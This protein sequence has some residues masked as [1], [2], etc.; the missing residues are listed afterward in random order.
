M[1]TIVIFT[2]GPLLGKLQMSVP[3]IMLRRTTVAVL[4]LCSMLTL[5][6][7]FSIAQQEQSESKRRIVNRVVP[8]YPDLARRMNVKGI[9]KLEALVASNGSVKSLELKGGHPLLSQAAQNAILKWRWEPASHET[10]EPVE[11]RFDPR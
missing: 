11:V 10:R 4:A 9:V 6:P 8:A 2:T 5:T 7:G 1:V 3:P